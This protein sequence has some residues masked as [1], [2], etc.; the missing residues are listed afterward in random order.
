MKNNVH[1]VARGYGV[2]SQITQLLAQSRYYSLNKRTRTVSL[3]VILL[4][5]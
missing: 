2:G 3:C 1:D 4:M 5:K